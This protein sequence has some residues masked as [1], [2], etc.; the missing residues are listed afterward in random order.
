M[1]QPAAYLQ[2]SNLLTAAAWQLSMPTPAGRCAGVQLH[3]EELACAAGPASVEGAAPA[4]AA[5][6]S[7]SSSTSTN[8]DAFLAPLPAAA[9]ACAGADAAPAQM[10]PQTRPGVRSQKA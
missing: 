5:A 9:A 7:S 1:R 3:K 2:C 6:R 10:E 4:G 8:L